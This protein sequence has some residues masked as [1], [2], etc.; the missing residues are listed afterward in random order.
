MFTTFMNQTME[1]Y[2][3]TFSDS[4]KHAKSM[5]QSR[6]AIKELKTIQDL[7]DHERLG[8]YDRPRLYLYQFIR[9]TR[10]TKRGTLDIGEFHLHL[11]TS[12]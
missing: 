1:R 11:R 9:D 5:F 8:H 4:A 3:R 10:N 7:L 12:D 2:S 6:H